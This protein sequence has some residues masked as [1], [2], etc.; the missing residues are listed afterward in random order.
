MMSKNHEIARLNLDIKFEEIK[1]MNIFIR[2]SKGW[3]RAIRDALG[4][5]TTQLAKRLDVAQPRVF[6]IEK[7]EVLGNLKFKTLE[8]VAQALDCQLVYALVPNKKLETMAYEQA[9]KKAKKML[10]KVEHNMKL[11]NQGSK[12]TD[13]EFEALVEEFLK[14]S[15]ARLWDED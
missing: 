6:S 11:E 14:G 15:Q 9:E 7:D 4:L 1:K 10:S 5:T 2:P 12:I 8:N 3:I 13:K